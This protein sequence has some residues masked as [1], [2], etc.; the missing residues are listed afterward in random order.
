MPLYEFVCRE[1][2]PFEERRSLEEPREMVSCPGCGAGARRVYSVPGVKRIAPGLS[3]AMD[4]VEKSAH[5]PEVVRRPAGDVAPG[6][7]H[8]HAHGRPWALGH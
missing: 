8:R 6:H 1:C 4:R 2:G 7:G 5:E 3:G